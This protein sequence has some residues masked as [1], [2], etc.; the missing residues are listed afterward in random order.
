MKFVLIP[1]GLDVALEGAGGNCYVKTSC[2]EEWDT[3]TRDLPAVW[4]QASGTKW[5]FPKVRA[6]NVDPS[7]RALMV[8]KPQEGCPLRGLLRKNTEILSRS[9]KSRL[10]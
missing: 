4:K 7:S 6:P 10:L 2:P 1:V 9:L 3:Q 8:R 5:E